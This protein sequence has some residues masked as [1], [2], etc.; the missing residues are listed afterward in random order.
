ME[1]R[2]I[3]ENKI[4]PYFLLLPQLSIV[5]IFF[6]LPGA[7]ALVLSMFREDAFGI[8]REFVGFENFQRLFA[9]PNYLH[10]VNIT[11]IFSIS[12]MILAMS[13]A[14]YLAVMADR[15]IRGNNFYKTMIIWPYAVAPVVSG[16][17]WMFLF[18]PIVGIITYTLEQ[19]GYKWNHSLNA[20]QAFL[21]VVI[22]ASW[23]QISYNFLFFLA[24][25]QGIPDSLIEAAAIDGAKPGTR[26]WKVVFPL[27]SPTTFFL[28][29]MNVMY[30]F[31]QTFGIIHQ[32]TSGGPNQATNILVY[33]VY[34]DGFIGLNLGGS[35][36]QSVV[37]M[38]IVIVLTV[39]QFRF[40]ERK[41]EY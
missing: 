18:N 36:A 8:S 40:L 27:L 26:F 21:L 11:F 17:M 35:S 15:V 9:D 33:K 13:T 41:V 39:L 37:L 34:R 38:I 2:V 4:L 30:S 16:V 22:A 12:V 28:I 19:F 14:L 29:V 25:L 6:I 1:K 7:Q 23:K 32:V 3:F 31:F 5:F 24:G 20:S 10:S